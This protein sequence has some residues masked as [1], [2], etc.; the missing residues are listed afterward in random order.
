VRGC[1]SFLGCTKDFMDTSLSILPE[2]E[3]G[4]V[5][6]VRRCGMRVRLKRAPTRLQHRATQS[7]HPGTLS[8]LKMESA[9]NALRL[10]G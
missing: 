8:A 5:L 6:V 9:V 7:H 10:A 3:L 4:S 2:V 1:L